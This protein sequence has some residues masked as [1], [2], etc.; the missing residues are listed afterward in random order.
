MRLGR[1]DWMG[2]TGMGTNLDN[3]YMARWVFPGE[4][5]VFP[6]D[7]YLI[8]AA[9]AVAGKQCGILESRL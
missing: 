8:R 2:G 9:R 1:W 7:T 4:G 3:R 6:R 5:D